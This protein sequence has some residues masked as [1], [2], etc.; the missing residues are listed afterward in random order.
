MTTQTFDSAKHPRIGDGTFTAV[1]R[2]EGAALS[3]PVIHIPSDP[4]LHRLVFED[5]PSRAERRGYARQA[6]EQALDGDDFNM[7]YTAE[8]QAGI[9]AEMARDDSTDR[10]LDHLEENPC[11]AHQFGSTAAGHLNALH[12]HRTEVE[13]HYVP[14]AEATYEAAAAH[15]TSSPDEYRAA[16]RE[17]LPH[18]PESWREQLL[19]HQGQQPES[20]QRDQLAKLAVTN[21]RVAA[22]QAPRREV[23]PEENEDFRTHPV[24]ALESRIDGLIR[25]SGDPTTEENVAYLASSD[26]GRHY[27]TVNI[28]IIGM[29]RQQ[30]YRWGT[31]DRS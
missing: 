24:T 13:S 19:G 29:A 23:S 2:P 17:H 31:G 30:A 8:Q 28:K 1:T 6:V 20:W 7:L 11:P 27:G 15:I 3:G 5:R 26:E 9:R 14:T 10:I 4:S 25:L 22:G 16:L 18:L 12:E 21:E